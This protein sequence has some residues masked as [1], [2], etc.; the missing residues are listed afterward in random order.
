[1]A[2]HRSGSGSG[3]AGAPP[4]TYR[5]RH[6]ER[7]DLYRILET[8]F[9]AY[10]YVHSERFEPD[11]G[12]LRSVVRTAVPAYL[13]CGRLFGGFARI[14]C[15]RCR[16]E[17]L[18]AFSCRMRNLCPSCQSKRS[19][20]FALWLT[21]EVLLDVPH[22]HVVFT[23]PK[24]LRGL[25]ERERR[26]HGV[27]A[28][29]AFETL[30]IALTGAA[31]E[32]E[33]VPGAVVALQTFGSFGANFHPHLHVIA[34]DGVFTRDGRFHPVVWPSESDLCER[35]RKTYLLHLERAERLRPE[36][37]ARL[38]AWQ[39]SGFSVKT[40][41]R[42][43]AAERQRLERLARYATRVV[44][45]VGAVKRAGPGRVHIET[46]R[47]PRTG[48]TI[49][50]LDELEFV[51]AVCQQIPDRR[52]HLVR[53]YGAYASRNRRSLRA[54]RDALA[55]GEPS[56]PCVDG[57]ERA[58][59]AEGPPAFENATSLEPALPGSAEA[60]RRQAWARLIR[61]VFE[62]DPMMCLRCKIAMEVVALITE[63]AVID[64]ILRHSKAHG[65]T[66][67]FEANPPRAPPDDPP[68]A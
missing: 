24:R 54:A 10:Q 32:P 11:A 64:K 66:S 55:V 18:L 67:P 12:P 60:V 37:R 29:A 65:L 68:D 61:R 40:T 30:R 27:M 33:A 14:R 6:P 43:A 62:V 41:Q 50:D 48:Q 47:D 56:T 17:H 52:L 4:R 49:L 39:H 51:H 5:P 35:F 53:Y 59:R 58:S 26:L 63:P 21:D 3:G 9:E 44:V 42:I 34:T 31:S 45:A 8:C 22:V 1:M 2:P 28:R 7:T 16:A 23:I 15:P 13:D 25:I 36:T 19:Q 46:P 38:L 20:V 57:P